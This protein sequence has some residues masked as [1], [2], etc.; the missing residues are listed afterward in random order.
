[1][2]VSRNMHI[3]CM[4]SSICILWV[5]D[6]SETGNTETTKRIISIRTVYNDNMNTH[7]NKAEIKLSENNTPAYKHF[8][9]SFYLHLK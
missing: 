6:A 2:L 4:H 1:M 7:R 9:I 8:H 5:G 3:S